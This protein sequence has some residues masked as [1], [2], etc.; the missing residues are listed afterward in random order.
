MNRQQK[1]AAIEGLRHILDEAM[2]R[3]AIPSPSTF[4]VLGHDDPDKGYMYEWARAF[5]FDSVVS[6]SEFD[7]VAAEREGWTIRGEGAGRMATYTKK[8]FVEGDTE[9]LWEHIFR[10]AQMGSDNH[11][12]ALLHLMAT[13]SFEFNRMAKHL[14]ETCVCHD[15]SAF[16]RAVCP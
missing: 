5:L 9:K 3:N 1:R 12:N 15:L 11:I 16:V 6:L 13:A 8:S 7:P 4:G 2:K 14:R 10:K